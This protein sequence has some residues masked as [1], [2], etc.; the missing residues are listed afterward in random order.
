MISDRNNNLKLIH[1]PST[2][3]IQADALS[4]RAD[5]VTEE[6]DELI[7][8]LPNDLFISIIAEDLRDKIVDSTLTDELAKK[9]TNCLDKQLP[10][11]L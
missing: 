3:L 6:D 2:K 5:H 9:I 1:V 7:T 10:P 8:M 4:R 11:P